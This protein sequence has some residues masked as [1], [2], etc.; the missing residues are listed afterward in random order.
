MATAYWWALTGA[1]GLLVVVGPSIVRQY[2]D[3]II[4]PFLSPKRAI[5]VI[6]LEALGAGVLCVSIAHLISLTAVSTVLTIMGAAFGTVFF[7]AV[8]SAAVIDVM[9]RRTDGQQ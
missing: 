8:V 4:G 5:A 6:A 1:G 2:G 9:G 7:V 3:R